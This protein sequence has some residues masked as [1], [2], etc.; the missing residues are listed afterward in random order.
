MVKKSSSIRCIYT[1]DNLPVLRSMDS[2]TVDLIYLD[3]PFNSG[4]QWENPVNAGGKRAMASFKDTW[5]LSDTH[6]DEEYSLGLQYPAAIPLIDSLYAINGG[7]WKAYLIYMGVRLAEMRRI[8]KLSGSIYYHCDST[9]SHGIKL[10]MDAIFGGEQFLNDTIWN[11]DGPQSPSTRKFATKHDNIIRYAKNIRKIFTAQDDMFKIMEVKESQLKADYKKDEHGYFYDLPP[12]D[13]TD[14][15]IRKLMAEGRVRKTKNG[16]TRIK[17]YLIEKDGKYYRRKKI[18]SVW[19][20][21]PSLGQSGGKQ[22]IGYPTQKPLMLLERII[23]TSSKKGDLVL[24]P[25]C[26]CATTCHAAEVLGRQWIGIDFAEEA[27]KLIVDRL[28]KESDKQLKP[29]FTDIEHLIKLPKR[30]DLPKRTENAVLKPRLY[31]MQ[32]KQC[33]GPC[34]ENGNGRALPIDTMDFDHIIAKNRGGQDT[35]DNIQLL[36]RN[37]NATKGDRGMD[38]LRQ[39]ILRRR[40]KETIRLWRQKWEA[41]KDKMDD[42]HDD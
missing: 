22:K 21:I 17:Y 2:A 29:S 36:C 40:S 5:E 8:L 12:G 41:Q 4:K 7:S 6:A 19:T 23:K 27:S 25:F 30:T 34:G 38:Y 35:D 10:L 18:S 28:Q 14:A 20:D 3:P 39:Q 24:D 9:M 13:Y 32:N 11:Y 15:S 26:G 31:Q 42:L 33:A 16:K 37:C 1:G